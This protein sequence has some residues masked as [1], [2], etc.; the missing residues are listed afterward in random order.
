MIPL[1]CK[2]YFTAGIGYH[3]NEWFS[4]YYINTNAHEALRFSHQVYSSVLSWASFE[5]SFFLSG[6]LSIVSFPCLH[7]CLCLSVCLYSSPPPPNVLTLACQR[8]KITN[9]L[10]S[11]SKYWRD[12]TDNVTFPNVT[13]IFH[14]S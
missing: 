3:W 8:K 1:T 11:P 5:K 13:K 6:L 12:T 14:I 4:N 9:Q 2:V 7:Y 10:L